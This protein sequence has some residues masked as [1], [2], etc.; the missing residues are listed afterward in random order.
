SVRSLRSFFWVSQDGFCIDAALE[1]LII[2]FKK[3]VTVFYR[4]I[5]SLLPNKPYYRRQLFIILEP[6]LELRV[7]ARSTKDI[8]AHSS[9]RKHLQLLG[10]I[11]KNVALNPSQLM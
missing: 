7:N 3:D 10:R 8:S 11:E 1:T 5:F 4:N 6:A 2:K 9:H